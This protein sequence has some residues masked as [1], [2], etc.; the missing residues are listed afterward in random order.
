MVVGER[1]ACHQRR[2][3]EAV[4]QLGQFTQRLGGARL[5]DAAAGV[6]HRALGGEDQPRRL[7]D[8]PRMALHVRAVAGQRGEHVVVARPVPRHVVGQ[9]VLRDVDQRRAG[10]AGLGDVE[11]L[12]DRHRDVVGGH[13]E[14]VV[15]RARAGDADR[16]ALLERIGADRPGRH[17]TGDRDHRDRVHVGVHQRRDEVG[18]R[19]TGGHHGHTGTAGD[20]GIALRHVARTLLVTHEHVTDR[21]VHQRVVGGQDAPARVAEHQVDVLVL[22]GSDECLG[23]G[24]SLSHDNSSWCGSASGGSVIRET[25]RKKQTTP[26]QGGREHARRWG[27]RATE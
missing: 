2:D 13:H 18:R 15:L 7:L 16:V 23:S 19:R 21:A 4:G 12:A 14:F 26:R 17:L 8:H 1:A 22:Q 6:D 5:E 9:A 3:H 11:R 25:G 10:A 27:R 24:D 20:V